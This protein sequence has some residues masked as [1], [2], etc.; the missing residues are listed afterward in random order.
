M[1]TLYKNYWNIYSLIVNQFP[2]VYIC[3]NDYVWFNIF[4]EKQFDTDQVKNVFIHT[5]SITHFSFSSKI[6]PRRWRKW[7]PFRSWW[8]HQ[9]FPRYRPFVREIHR[10]PMNFPH[11]GQWRG[12]LM[13]SLI[14]T[15]YDVI[16]M[17]VTWI[18]RCLKCPVIRLFVQHLVPAN[19]KET[20][21]LHITSHLCWESNWGR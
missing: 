11:K 20:A 17:C 15:H 12:A 2:F 19:N 13:F 3:F 14:S 21:M 18:S 8:R 16:V 9:C 4:Q 6:T 1:L 7:L 5:K 10:S